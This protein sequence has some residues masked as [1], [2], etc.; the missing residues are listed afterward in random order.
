MCGSPTHRHT[1]RPVLGS[2]SAVDPTGARPGQR[3]A[4]R[5][6]GWSP[7]L[8]QGLHT[9]TGNFTGSGPLPGWH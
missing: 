9:R 8:F 1:P 6:R 4:R 7:E 2:A 5:S 3:P